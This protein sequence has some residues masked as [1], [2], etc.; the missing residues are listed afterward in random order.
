MPALFFPPESLSL[1]GETKNVWIEGFHIPD[2]LIVQSGIWIQGAGSGVLGIET[3]PLIP[4]KT[5][6]GL[7][8]EQGQSLVHAPQQIEPVLI[9]QGEFT[10]IPPFSH[11]QSIELEVLS[12]SRILCVALDGTLAP[13]FLGRLGMFLNKVVKQTS[14]PSQVYLVNQIVQVVVRHSGTGSASYQLQQLLWGL[15]ASH[16]GQP[17]PLNGM[18]SYEISKVVDTLRVNEYKENLSLAQMAAI[19][20]MPVETFRKRFSAE[21]GMPPLSYL[22]FCKIEKAKELL[23]LHGSIKQASQA[24]G[25]TDLYYFSKQ[26]KSIVGVS[27]SVYLKYI[28][29]E[30]TN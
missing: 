13:L 23:R 2:S 22:L 19:A 18:L 4:S 9:S 26:F 8:L 12:D 20:K 28:K 30:T 15:L 7:F 5:W 10:V 3:Y 17:I 29:N 14:L 11:H 21:I 6:R 24:V 25:I 1:H 16:A 27:P